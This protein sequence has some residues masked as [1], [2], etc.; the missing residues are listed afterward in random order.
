MAANA[1]ASPRSGERT[2]RVSGSSAPARNCPCSWARRCVH[3]RVTGQDMSA[4]LGIA[5]N[6]SLTWAAESLFLLVVPGGKQRQKGETHCIFKRN[7]NMALSASTNNFS[8]CCAGNQLLVPAWH[9]V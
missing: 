7:A 4:S 2:Y 8:A 5:A 1:L 9:Q 3:T 6:T